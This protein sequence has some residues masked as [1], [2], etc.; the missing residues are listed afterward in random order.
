MDESRR[1]TALPADGA[2]SGPDGAPANRVGPRIGIDVGGTFTDLTLS[3]PEQ[4]R[5][6]LHKEPSTPEDPARAVSNGFAAVVARAGIDPGAVE[7]ITHGTT[8][9][10][11][12]IVQRRGAKIALVTSRGN[13]DL[14]EIGRGTM[15]DPL[16]FFDRKEVPLVPRSHVLETGFRIDARGGV[17]DAGEDEI[18]ALAQRLGALDVEAF[19]VVVLNAHLKPDSE[20]AFA[21]RLSAASGIEAWPS[22]TIWPQIREYERGV[23]A[24]MNAYVAPLMRRYLDRIEVALGQQGFAGRLL[25]ATSNGGTLSVASARE[26]PIDTLLSGP[27]S[28]V[29]AAARFATLAGY[30]EAV[31]VD[32]GGTSSDMS[33]L[34]RSGVGYSTGARIGDFPLFLPVV[35]V[36]AIGAGGGSVVSVDGFGVLK[37]GPE[38]AGAAPGPVCYGR[39]GTQPTVTDCYLACGLISEERMLG[40]QIKLSREA[41]LAALARIAPQAGFSGVD[42]SEQV[43]WAAIRVATAKMATELRKGLAERGIDPRNHAL[44]A[45]GGAGPTNGFLLAAEARVGRA[46]VPTMPGTFCALG[47]MMSDLK[48]DFTR[49]AR[50]VLDAEGETAGWIA[51]AARELTAEADAWLDPDAALLTRRAYR[52]SASMKY[53]AQSYETDVEIPIA[54]EDA[55]LR[56]LFHAAHE[57][58]FGFRDTASPIVIAS[59]Q[60]TAIGYLAHAEPEYSTGPSRPSPAPATRPVFLGGEWLDARIVERRDLRPGDVL[61]GPVIVE[62]DDT[63]TVIPPRWHAQIDRHGTIVGTRN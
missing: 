29:V 10:L 1:P 48:R 50:R 27:A 6:L 53:R 31:T 51:A 56:E 7:I 60:L 21:R 39:G 12:A 11:N 45:F 14:L 15:K 23:V 42:A 37:V 22:G 49:A 46:L 52:L 24:V 36:S 18:A 41:A 16:N 28:G 26:R 4:G 44:I 17:A 30:P 59:I 63:T 33:V 35:N 9:G 32:M 20:S 54:P 38:S 61:D 25:I 57:R 3:L 5:I 55:E 47:S 13:R 34:S 8:I 2:R 62:Q 19:A 43:A 58:R 40:G